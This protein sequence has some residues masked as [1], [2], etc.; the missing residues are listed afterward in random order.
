MGFNFPYRE[1]VVVRG[2][3]L[4]VVRRLMIDGDIKVRSG[5][6][7]DPKTVLGK[8]DARL[9]TVRFAVA[10]PLGVPPKEVAKHLVK[11]VG[12][13]FNAGEP[14]ARLRRGLRGATVDAPVTGNLIELDSA[15]GIAVMMPSNAGEA[16][17]LVPG[18]V[19][20]V[21]G[22]Q[23]VTIRTIGSRVVG[24][25]GLGNPTRGPLKIAVEAADQELSANRVT[26]DMAGA[27]V[28]GGAF[29][30]AAALVKLAEVRAAAVVT[31]GLVERE[32]ASFLGA[33]GDDRLAAWRPSPV[34]HALGDG[35]LSRV[36]LMATEGFGKLPMNEPAFALLK[37]LAGQTAVLLTATNVSAPLIRPGLIVPNEA[38]LDE[39]GLTSSAALAMGAYV[40]LV[41]PSDLGLTG[42]I[43]SE[44]RRQRFGDGRFVDVIDVELSKRGKRSVPVA[45]VEVLV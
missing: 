11:P 21:N 20:F 31:G 25:V 41:A 36:S 38:A 1:A 32:I 6:R 29:A 37:E 33:P 42:I 45:N 7:V 13:T 40:R 39:D 26:A 43:A 2:H 16:L 27:V 4:R 23:S 14:I 30:G 18:D 34:G 3:E 12:S 19:E 8:A 9:L 44:P 15:T 28:I 5:E 17:A 35:V 22:R 10:E 24:I